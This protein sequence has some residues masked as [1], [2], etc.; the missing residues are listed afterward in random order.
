MSEKIIYSMV[1]IKKFHPGTDKPV[2][3]DISLSYFY[4]AKIGVLGLNGAG[5]STLLRIMAGVDHEF[6]GEAHLTEGYTVG[7][8]AQE[9]EL[10][11]SKTVKEIVQ[12]GAG[13]VAA[14]LKEFDEINMKFAEDLDPGE[15][16]KVLTRQAEVQDRLDALNAWTLDDR[17]N[18]AMEALR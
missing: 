2:I 5:K 1:G 6:V 3:R 16:D 14:L 18:F 4:G 13:E 17:L 12:E 11:E 8:L 10:D 9:P 7:Y 15:M